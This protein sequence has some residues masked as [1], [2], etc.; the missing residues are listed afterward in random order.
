MPSDPNEIARQI[1]EEASVN[2]GNGAQFLPL[3]I[4]LEAAAAIATI[5][6]ACV[7]KG[8]V[9]EIVLRAAAAPHSL[10][11]GHVRSELYAVLPQEYRSPEYV[12]QVIQV[13]AAK[14]RSGE[15][16]AN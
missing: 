3:L 6:A 12:D 5:W 16:A 11:A 8:H 4:L 1:L 2:S 13:A 9:R 7:R 15:I 10:A 14:I